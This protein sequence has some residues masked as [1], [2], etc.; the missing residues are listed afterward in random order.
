M[1]KMY[2]NVKGSNTKKIKIETFYSKDRINWFNG[3]YEDRGYY[4]SARLTEV[5]ERN[6]YIQES[7]I[8]DSNGYKMLIKPVSKASKKQEDIA[9]KMA[10]EDMNILIDKICAENDIETE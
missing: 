3:K 2:I 4:L 5:T 9:D 1:I 10:I 8:L 6:G 7:Y